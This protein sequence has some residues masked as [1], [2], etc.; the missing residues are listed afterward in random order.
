ML[1]YSDFAIQLLRME[2]I[3]STLKKEMVEFVSITIVLAM[4]VVVQL[5]L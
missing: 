2:I 1:N 4:V 5:A 3:M